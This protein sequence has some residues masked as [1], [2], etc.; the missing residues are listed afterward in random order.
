MAGFNIHCRCLECGHK[1][2]K[3]VEADSIEA[4]GAIADPPCPKCKKKKRPAVHGGLEEI[5]ATQSAPSVNHNG[6]RSQAIDETARIVMEDYGLSDLKTNIREGDSMAPNLTP[7][8]R[9]MGENFWGGRRG[10]KP[11]MDG[12]QMVSSAM[13]GAFLP[14]RGAQAQPGAVSGNEM[15]TA[16]HRTRSRPKTTIIGSSD[17]NP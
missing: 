17:G 6:P 4:V 13:Q 8:Q 7:Q 9:K 3:R 16:L 12:K 5:I 11:M 10:Q 2:K 14:G 1:Y 15:L